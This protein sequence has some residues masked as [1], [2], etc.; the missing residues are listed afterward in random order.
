MIL[1]GQSPRRCLIAGLTL[2][3][4]KAAS[5]R[6]AAYERRHHLYCPKHQTVSASGA[7]R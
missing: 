2:R 7:D 5:Q 3:S 4:D 1:S 6:R